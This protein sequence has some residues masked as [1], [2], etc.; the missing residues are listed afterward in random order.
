MADARTRELERQLFGGDLSV[1]PQLVRIHT[2]N[3]NFLQVMHVLIHATDW[4]TASHLTE[5]IAYQIERGSSPEFYPSHQSLEVCPLGHTGNAAGGAIELW[6]FPRSWADINQIVGDQVYLDDARALVESYCDVLSCN[7]C[8]AVWMCPDVSY[9]RG[10]PPRP[11]V[12]A[13]RWRLASYAD[14]LAAI[15]IGVALADALVEHHFE[16]V[17]RIIGEDCRNAVERDPAEWRRR[18][19]GIRFSH[20]AYGSLIGQSMPLDEL[21]EIT[22]GIENIYPT[23]DVFE[24]GWGFWI[25]RLDMKKESRRGW[26]RFRVFPGSPNSLFTDDLICPFRA[27]LLQLPLHPI[28]ARDDDPSAFRSILPPIIRFP[29]Q[30]GSRENTIQNV[31]VIEVPSMSQMMRASSLNAPQTSAVLFDLLAHLERIYS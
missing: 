31:E 12:S 8:G 5:I 19:Y 26:Y 13:P 4:K 30:S 15:P 1:I 7:I 2:A 25:N 3:N 27:E 23:F 21:V 28:S 9:R 18:R 24:H 6:T 17:E 20:N 22:A 10:W 14:L 29:P 16:P 11:P